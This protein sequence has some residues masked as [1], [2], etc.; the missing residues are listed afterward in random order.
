MILLNKAIT[1][2]KNKVTYARNLS[3]EAEIEGKKHFLMKL[4]DH[5]MDG[6]T[7]IA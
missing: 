6:A 2:V 1:L 3:M 4:F 7:G 5:R